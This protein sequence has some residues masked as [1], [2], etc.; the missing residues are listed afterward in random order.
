VADG[1]FEGLRICH[2]HRNSLSSMVVARA[3]HA[4]MDG[5]GI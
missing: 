4:C 2:M 5:I 1:G 3:A